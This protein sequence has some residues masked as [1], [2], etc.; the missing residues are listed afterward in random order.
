MLTLFFLISSQYE[1]VDSRSMLGRAS[2]VGSQAGSL[3]IRP[4]GAGHITTFPIFNSQT[5]V[6]TKITPEP[7]WPFSTFAL[8]SSIQLAFLLCQDHF[9]A[10]VTD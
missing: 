3:C 8:K 4:D 2:K 6:G 9:V 1:F 10:K 7:N 5:C